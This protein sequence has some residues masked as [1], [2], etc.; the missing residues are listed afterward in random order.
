MPVVTS[1]DGTPIVYD[2]Q[3]TGPA[4]VVVDGALTV[5]KSDNKARL[6]ELLAPRLTVLTYDRRGRGDS[7]DTPPYSVAREI[8][9]VAAVID[10]AGGSAAL[11]GHSSG[12]C[13]ALEAALALNEGDAGD[14]AGVGDGPVVGDGPGATVT[15]LAM[16]EA[17]YD[18]D[19]DAGPGWHRY[20]ADMTTALEEGRPGD[21]AAL[22]MAF[23][24][25]PAKQIDVMRRAPFWRDIEAVAPTLAYDHAGLMGTDR[26][27]PAERARAVGVPT[28]VMYGSEGAPFM[29]QTAVTLE[30][31][32]PGAEL[33]NIAGE[34][35]NVSAQA[36][37][38]VLA[39]FFAR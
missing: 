17:P 19:P 32:I 20:L 9:D 23:V 31:L 6:V 5:R 13:L 25:T 14:R 29:A 1:R 3:G 18:D 21:A 35:H 33:R 8:E 2:M 37:A 12:G 15:R 36:L 10:A 39:E 26:S 27:I 34:G 16:Y 11:Y 24:G 38:P 28:L 22:F 4:L 30:K 7:G